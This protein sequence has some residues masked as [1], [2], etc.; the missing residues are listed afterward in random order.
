MTNY[1]RVIAAEC[2]HD[3]LAF[4]SPAPA[5]DN[6]LPVIFQDNKVS[7]RVSDDLIL[8]D[9]IDE[10]QPGLFDREFTK[11]GHFGS[12]IQATY[13]SSLVTSHITSGSD[14]SVAREAGT[15]NLDT[16]LNSFTSTLIPPPGKADG[17][18]CGAFGVCT[19]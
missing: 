11:L 17:R 18:Y 12:T 4:A 10:G 2:G 7:H 3:G 14:D 8:P 5:L 15:R 6:I 19:K 9:M 13:L 1:S 16:A